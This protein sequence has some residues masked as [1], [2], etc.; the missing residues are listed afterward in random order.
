MLKKTVN[1]RHAATGR[2]SKI[3]RYNEY[4]INSTEYKHKKEKLK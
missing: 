1:E 3:Y 4:K 2:P